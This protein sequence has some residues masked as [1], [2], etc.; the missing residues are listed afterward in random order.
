[1]CQPII[2]YTYNGILS[3]PC[4]S[5]HSDELYSQYIALYGTAARDG[6]YLRASDGTK[7]CSKCGIVK[8]A[9][10]Y[11]VTYI[12]ET[13]KPRHMAA[14]K[15]CQREYVRAYR[16]SSDGKAMERR[17]WRAQLADP[18]ENLKR[19]A[20]A[21]VARALK[22]GK[23]VRG[24]CAKAGTSPCSGRIE[25]HHADH[26]KPLDVT[27]MCFGHHYG[28]EHGARTGRRRLA[29]A[30]LLAVLMGASAACTSSPVDPNAGA[31][32]PL[33]SRCAPGD[34]TTWAAQ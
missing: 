22:S 3:G 17:V 10:D 12:K 15:D 13:G 9:S 4:K 29:G 28:G 14:C 33:L 6:N 18:A 26:S 23:L 30:F 34:T 19:K 8:P 20:R 32:Q 1:M 16:K 24:E 27:W 11:Y 21:A 5:L 31:C 7:R 25:A 2:Y